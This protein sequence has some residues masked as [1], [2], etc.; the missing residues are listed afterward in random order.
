[1]GWA[2]AACAPDG[3]DSRSMSAGEQVALQAGCA[4]CHGPNGEGGSGPKL[5]GLYGSQVELADGSTVIADGAYLTEAIRDPSARQTAGYGLMPANSLNDAE[6]QA[7][8]E[9]IRS[10]QVVP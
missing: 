1:M 3:D 5:R 6:I 4:S 9:F 10:L 8:V 7:V 2:L